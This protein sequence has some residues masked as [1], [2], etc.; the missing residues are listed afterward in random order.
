MI[1]QLKEKE[2]R[3]LRPDRSVE[4]YS[5]NRFSNATQESTKL[6][7]AVVM[8][9]YEI[10]IFKTYSKDRPSFNFMISL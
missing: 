6:T 5:T 3:F 2:Q 8:C 9:K 4:R 1:I 10:Q 7:E